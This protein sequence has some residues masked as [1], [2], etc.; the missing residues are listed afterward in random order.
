MEN[1]YVLE[2]PAVFIF[3]EAGNASDVLVLMYHTL[4]HHISEDC[5]CNVSVFL[6]FID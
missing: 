3:R 6:L 5:N 4:Q 2:E 1:T